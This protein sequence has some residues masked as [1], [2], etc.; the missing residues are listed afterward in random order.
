[1]GRT[2]VILFWIDAHALDPIQRPSHFMSD[3]R[4]TRYHSVHQT[5]ADQFGDL[6]GHSFVEIG[7]APSND[8]YSSTLTF[9]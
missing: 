6:R 8:H 5:V 3:D 7:P 1:M 9:R 2:T 4:G